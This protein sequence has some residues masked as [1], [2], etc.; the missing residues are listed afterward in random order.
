[1]RWHHWR[2]RL[3]PGSRLA[4]QSSSLLLI[5]QLVRHGQLRLRFLL[6]PLLQGHLFLEHGGILPLFLHLSAL[7]RVLVLSVP[8]ER[9]LAS[10]ITPS[11][12]AHHLVLSIR[13]DG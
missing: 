12:Q 1:M 2:L 4:H 7:G 11:L 3:G 6:L 9:V 13:A 10:C 8:V 5:E